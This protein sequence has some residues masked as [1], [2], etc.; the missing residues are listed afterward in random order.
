MIHQKNALSLLVHYHLSWEHKR[1]KIN[2]S[3]VNA[4][5]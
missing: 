2:I 5:Y 4:Y 3:S 1:Q